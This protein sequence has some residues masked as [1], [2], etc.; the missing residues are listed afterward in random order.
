VGAVR[1]RAVARRRPLALAGQGGQVP[2]ARRTGG[3]VDDRRQPGDPGGGRQ[4]LDDARKPPEVAGLK[5]LVDQGHDRGQRDQDQQ[6]RAVADP[7]GP[8]QVN[9]HS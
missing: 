8:A 9:T 2:A 1:V 7:G 3:L 6:Q 5:R 4:V